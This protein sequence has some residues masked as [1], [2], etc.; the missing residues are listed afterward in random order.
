M[1]LPLALFIHT[2]GSPADHL[3]LPAF[4]THE[5]VEMYAC[6]GEDYDYDQFLTYP[7]R[8]G[9]TDKDISDPKES[10]KS[11]DEI[12]SFFQNWF[13]WTLLSDILRMLLQTT[14]FVRT[15]KSGKAV[16]TTK[17][18]PAL[19][20]RW[21]V[22]DQ[23]LS[24]SAQQRHARRIDRNLWRICNILNDWE[25]HRASPL[26]HWT[27]VYFM[28]LGQYIETSYKNVYWK[29]TD[30]GST[31]GDFEVIFKSHGVVP[32]WF[33]E[34]RRWSGLGVEVIRQ[35]MLADG[36]CRSDV[37]RLE[38]TLQIPDTYYISLLRPPEYKHG[39][40]MRFGDKDT[41]TSR[42]TYN[43][44]IAC[45]QTSPN[46]IHQQCSR[47]LCTA[48]QVDEYQYKT[49][50][51]FSHCNCALEQICAWDLVAILVNDQVPVIRFGKGVKIVPALPG[52]RYVAISHV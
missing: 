29:C 32:D 20:K 24:K 34:N 40:G 10:G 31:D 50:H 16:I 35:R 26:D 19:V 13:F 38:S 15:N 48:H 36:W 22:R 11:L 41:A 51:R 23:Y 14:E 8:K 12:S 1:S 33:S 30:L 18:L 39:S 52:H 43:S 6:G 21:F 17:Q 25:V 42:S 46:G 44:T 49:R 47:F 5:A 7:Y 37:Q 4:P 2:G 27:T 9:W 45:T 3:A 28:M